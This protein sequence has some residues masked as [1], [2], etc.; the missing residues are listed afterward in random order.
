MKRALATTVR[1]REIQ[2]VIPVTQRHKSDAFA[3]R[4]AREIKGFGWHVG[5]RY[6]SQEYEKAR[7]SKKEN[8]EKRSMPLRL[9]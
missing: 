3:E 4:E 2:P 9:R 8:H 7:S 1:R 6:G 5:C